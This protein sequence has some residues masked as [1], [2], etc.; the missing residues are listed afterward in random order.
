M[1]MSTAPALY[2]SSVL[3]TQDLQYIG[4]VDVPM[5]LLAR[6]DFPANFFA[7]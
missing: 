5:T 7:E 6:K 4:Q 1:G 3:P 2:K